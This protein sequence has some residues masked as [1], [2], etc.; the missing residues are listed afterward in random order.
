MAIQAWLFDLYPWRSQMVLWFLTTDGRRLRIVDAFTYR[1]YAQGAGAKL[2]QLARYTRS[3]GWVRHA[4]FEDKIDFATGRTS[5]ALCLEVSAYDRRP[6]LLAY[7]GALEEDLAFYNCDLDISAYYL[8][9]KKLFPCCWYDLELAGD[10]LASF[11]AQEGQFQEEL[12]MPPLATLELVLTRDHLIPL[13]GGNGLALTWEGRTVELEVAEVPTL[14][15]ELA[16]Y[17]QR[18]DPD[19]LVSD[20]GD[21]HILPVLWRWSR[22]YRQPLPLDR[23]PAPPLRQLNPQG[24]SYFSYGRI[25]YQ[26]P[27]VPFYGR[28]HIDRRN[29]FFYREAGL[30]GLVQLSRLGQTPLQQVAR[31][32]PG[33]LITSM[34]LARA[35]ADNILIP[36]RKTEPEHFKTAAELL[37]V[38]KGG[39]VFQP[40]VGFYTQVAEI[41][42]ASMYP[43]IM[44]VH[45]ISPETVNCGCCCEPRTPEAEYVLCQ[46]REGLVP[47]TLK[48][49]LDLRARLKCRVRETTDPEDAA[50]YQA[51]QIA[52]KWILV[53]CFGYLGYKNARFGRIEAHEAVT[54]FGRDKLLAAKEICEA[55]GYEVLHGLTDCLWIRRSDEGGVENEVLLGLCGGGQRSV[56]PGLLPKNTRHLHRV[57]L[58]GLCQCITAATGITMALEGVYRWIVFLPSQQQEER[59]VPNRYF[60]VFGDGRLKYRGLMCRRR[61]TPPLVRQAQEVL[62]AFLAQ[63][64]DW[65]EG[66]ALREELDDAATDFRLRLEQGIVRPEELVITKILSRSP[67]RFR[68]QTH[69]ALAA[70]QLQAAGIRLVPGEKLRYIV[71]DR[72]GPPETRVLA[73][74]F[75][76]ALDRYDTEYYLELLAKAVDEVLWPWAV[77]SRSRFKMC[78]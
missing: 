28:W 77:G 69:T 29:S 48:P 63:V 65:E 49:I 7:L 71:R 72:Q 66:R 37:T 1:L 76:D 14:L 34:Q 78:A 3:R 62:L 57:E 33:T 73:A 25:V 51:R 46:R 17:F 35:T 40:P 27:S 67:D 20:W 44:A 41:D 56:N 61:D 22:Q 32:S 24:R 21:E 23:D 16:H 31:T 26:G 2:R 12:V 45:N 5:P 10:R 39:L 64:R 43:T 30:P 52:L 68:V 75:F 36:W 15:A 54:A 47:R 19:L 70:R 58:A 9:S 53:T 11:A 13:G 8:Y 50:G 38:D 60:G 18:L 42:F 74:P 4:Y 6:R 59:S 55:T